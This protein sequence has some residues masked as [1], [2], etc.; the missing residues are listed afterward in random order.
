MPPIINGQSLV[1][2]S[3]FD[4]LVEAEYHVEFL[5]LTNLNHGS[6]FS[7]IFDKLKFYLKIFFKFLQ[8]TIFGN[9]IIYLNGARS[10]GGTFRNLPFLIISKILRNK[11][12]LHFHCGDIDDFLNSQ[13]KIIKFF[14]LWAYKLPDKLIILSP[15]LSKNFSRLINNDNLVIIENGIN[16]PLAKPKIIRESESFKILYLSNLILSKGYF[17]ILIAVDYLV[18]KLSFK[19]IECN[20]CGEFLTSYD[21]PELNSIEKMKLD[22]H[23][24]ITQNNLSNHVNYKAQ[25]LD[26]E[27]NK[28]LNDSHILVLPTNYSTEAQ[29]L[30]IIEAISRGNVI[31]S[32]NFRAIPDMVINHYNGKFVAFGDP[33]SIAHNILYFINNPT[34]FTKYSSNS[35]SIFQK[36][37]TYD[38]FKCKILTLFERM[39]KSLE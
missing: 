9:Y 4:I 2:K 28:I 10:I 29:P 23:D 7:L 32:T 33:L 5:P 8:K 17:D 20:F 11:I 30:S 39:S 14:L 12:I 35:I 13:N 31:I 6:S 36:S 34:D 24:Y 37:F 16:S 27:K 19:N 1:T 21:D 15:T 3:I 25:I 38:S 26:E 18:N 22:F